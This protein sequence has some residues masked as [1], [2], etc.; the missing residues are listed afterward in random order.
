V[1]LMFSIIALFDPVWP[2]FYY[3]TGLAGIKLAFGAVRH[4]TQ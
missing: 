4:A 2:C 3:A 1:F